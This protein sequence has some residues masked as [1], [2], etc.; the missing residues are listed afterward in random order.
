MSV[1]VSRSGAVLAP[2]H[3]SLFHRVVRL[4]VSRRPTRRRGL[5]LCGVSSSLCVR[6]LC[7]PLG[8][9]AWALGHFGHAAGVVGE[10]GCVGDQCVVA[11]FAGADVVESAH[12]GF[13]AVGDGVAAFVSDD[14][15][16]S[17]FVVH[18]QE[19]TMRMYARQYVGGVS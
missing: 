12:E 2:Q 6:L 17:A 16:G 5:G 1:K 3:R 14:A 11:A 19:S 15:V 10:G 7:V 18:A 4:H 9:S 13:F 8:A